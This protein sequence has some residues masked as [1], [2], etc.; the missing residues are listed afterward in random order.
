MLALCLVCGVC[1]SVALLAVARLRTRLSKHRGAALSFAVPG[2]LVVLPVAWFAAHGEVVALVPLMTIAALCFAAAALFTPAT[3]IALRPFGAPSLPAS[4]STHATRVPSGEIA[5]CSNRC[6]A[7]SECTASSSADAVAAPLRVGWDAFLEAPGVC[8]ELW[9]G[10]PSRSPAASTIAT[11]WCRLG[12]AIRAAFE[13][14][15]ECLR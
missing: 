6:A 1:L 3:R 14:R 13:R 5:A 4:V 15:I 11:D 12:A 10:A 2:A 7:S 9:T 8:A